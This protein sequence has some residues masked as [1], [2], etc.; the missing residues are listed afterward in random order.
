M[1][2]LIIIISILIKLNIYKKTLINSTF[3]TILNI[4]I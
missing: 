4:E 2:S 3:L 1:K